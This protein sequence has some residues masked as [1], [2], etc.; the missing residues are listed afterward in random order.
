MWKASVVEWALFLQVL[1]SLPRFGRSVLKVK[2]CVGLLAV[3]SWK[4]QYLGSCLKKFTPCGSAHGVV[5]FVGESLGIL[6]T[7]C[8]LVTCEFARSLGSSFFKKFTFSF[9][10]HR[11]C[12]SMVEELLLHPSTTSTTKGVVCGVG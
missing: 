11:E 8:G 4:S 7:F 5:F 9:A 6:I 1:L 12:S 10:R 3:S 2:V